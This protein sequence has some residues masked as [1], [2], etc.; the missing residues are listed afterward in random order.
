MDD[1]ERAPE[2]AEANARLDGIT[3]DDDDRELIARRRRGEIS[4]EDFLAAAK[5]LV[6]RKA[7]G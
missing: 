4:H 7:Q 5:A 2:Q 1:A 3:L 6:T